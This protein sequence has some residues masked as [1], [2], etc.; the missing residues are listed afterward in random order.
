M[1]GQIK[2]GGETERKIIVRGVKPFLITEF[3]GTDS[4]VSVEDS[5]KE[6]KSVHVLTVKLKPD[7]PGEFN[8]TLRLWTDLPEDNKIDFQ[9]S[10]VVSP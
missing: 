6:N 3:Q 10:A 9:V 4:S 5:T 2:M 8:R 1:L 7:R